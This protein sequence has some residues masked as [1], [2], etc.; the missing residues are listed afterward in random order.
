MFIFTTRLTRTKLAVG[1]AAL[2]VLLIGII[3]LMTR[4]GGAE[5]A[6]SST[7]SPKG[8]KTT[9]DR[10][11]YLAGYGWTADPASEECQDV[12]IP[13]EFDSTFEE[14]NTLQKGQG[15]D[16]SKI[17]GKRVQR[18]IYSITDHPGGKGPVYASVLIYKNNVVGGDL[19]NP[20][21]DGFLQGFER[22]PT[23]PGADQP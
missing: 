3:I 22:P 19:Q 9:E 12:V 1:I 5:A 21:P 20:S 11:A 15:F 6:A 4:G 18:Y 7:P 23:L 13:K 14:Y 2:G 10:V 8:V 17:K 16:L